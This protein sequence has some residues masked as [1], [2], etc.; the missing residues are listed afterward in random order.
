MGSNGGLFATDVCANFKVT[1][2]C[3]LQ[4]K[5]VTDMQLEYSNRITSKYQFITF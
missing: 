2:T 3:K 5:L 1:S 4:Q